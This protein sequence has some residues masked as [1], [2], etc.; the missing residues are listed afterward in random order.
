MKVDDVVSEDSGKKVVAPHSSGKARAGGV[1]WDM[2]GIGVGVM[3]MLII[4]LVLSGLVTYAYRNTHK[5]KERRLAVH[6]STSLLPSQMYLYVLYIS[7][8]KGKLKLCIR[9]L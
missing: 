3:V 6:L 2:V 4:V 7:F 1:R 5:N 8:N 9:L